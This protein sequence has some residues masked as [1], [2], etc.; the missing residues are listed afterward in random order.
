MD[1]YKRSQ[2]HTR[3]NAE[4]VVY[5][6]KD[7]QGFTVQNDKQKNGQKQVQ[8]PSPKPKI[9]DS[10]VQKDQA[11]IINRESELKSKTKDQMGG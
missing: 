1:C 6:G 7:I 8:S 3:A 4:I 5:S 10:E 11:R 2:I 9:R